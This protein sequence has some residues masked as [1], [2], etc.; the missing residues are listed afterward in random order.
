MVETKMKC[1]NQERWNLLLRNL[2]VAVACRFC[3][4]PYLSNLII[5]T[6]LNKNDVW[7]GICRGIDVGAI[8]EN[9]EDVDGQWVVCYRYD[10]HCTN[11]FIDKLIEE[12]L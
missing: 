2:K 7:H 12:L 11:D 5:Q 10:D 3:C 1:F 4:L 9:W 6:G 8:K